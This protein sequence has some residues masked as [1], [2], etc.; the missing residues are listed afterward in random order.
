MTTSD[1]R[2]LKLA[3]GGR[4]LVEASA[5]TGKTWTIAALYLRLLLEPRDGG[6]VSARGI[7]VSTFTDAAAQELRQRIRARLQGAQ[8]LLASVRLAPHELLDRDLQD[9][10]V[11]HWLRTLCMSTDGSVDAGKVE[12]CHL[13]LQLALAELDQAPIGTLHALCHRILR[14]QPFASGMGFGQIELVAGSELGSELADDLWRQLAQSPEPLSAE[15]QVWFDA[16][17]AKLTRAL[18][19]ALKPGVHVP[20]PP[21]PDIAALLQ[22]DMAHA[23]RER[24][25][26]ASWF[27]STKSVWTR[28]LRG[29]ADWIDAGDPNTGPDEK[30]FADLDKPIETQIKPARLAEAEV[31]D[32]FAFAMHAAE[33]LAKAPDI[34]RARGLAQFAPTLRALRDARLQARG[35]L[36]FDAVI[37]RVHAALQA[38]PALAD[39]LH[40]QWPVAL[41]DEFQ[42]TDGLQ[43]D[44]LDR[45]HRDAMGSPRGRLVMIGDPKQAIYRF[46]GG[47]IDAY[48]RAACDV[49]PDDVMHLDTNYRSAGGYVVACNEFF[50][51]AGH[52]LSADTQHA[53]A[54]RDVKASSRRD[55]KPY[56]IDAIPVER[57]LVFHY[58]DI[59]PANADARRDAALDACA[60]HIVQLLSGTH[61]IGD[62]PLQPG[63]IAVLLPKNKHVSALRMRL[64]ARGVPCVG[65]GRSSVFATDWAHELQLL[66]HAAAEPG[67]P[68]LV[69]AALATRIGGMDYPGLRAL[70][71]AGHEAEWQ[72][73]LDRFAALHARWQ[74][75]GVL[76][77]VSEIIDAAAPRLVAAQDGERALTDLRHLGE[78]LQ[79]QEA[80]QPGHAQL[81]AWLSA[82]RDGDGSD[83][84][85][86]AN[87]R[88]LRIES[89]A[90][91]VQLMTLHAAKGLEFPVV[92]L[93]L[94][95]D[96]ASHQPPGHHG[97]VIVTD[98][99][100]GIRQ[101]RNDA[102][103]CEQ[104][105]R[106]DQEERFRLL[107]VA[108]T[109]AE[110]VCHVYVLPTD[111]PRDGR[112]GSTAVEDPERSPL[113][114][115]LVRARTA[116][117]NLQDASQHI[118]WQLGWPETSGIHQP[119]LAPRQAI[120]VRP[121]PPAAQLVR[122]HSFS[123]MLRGSHGLQEEHAATDE[124]PTVT[125]DII[126][127]TFEEARMTEDVVPASRAHPELAA[128]AQWRGTEIGLALHDVLEQRIV[129]VPIREQPDLVRDCLRK[130]GV[131]PW[132]EG[133]ELEQMLG[134]I[135]QRLDATLD[136]ELKSGLRLSDLP[137]HSLRAEMAFDYVLGDAST[138]RLRAVCR[139]AGE[140]ALMPVLAM[141]TLRG[142]MNGKIDLVFEHA[143]RFHVLDWK[144]NWLGDQLENYMPVTL[145]AA[146]DVHHYRLQALLYTV[147]LHRYLRMRLGGSYR[148]A[149]H[150]GD[151]IY[152]FLRAVGLAP[153]AGVWTQPFSPALIASVDAVLAGKSEIPA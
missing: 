115:L 70:A 87:G 29:L 50:D 94:M 135:A 18:G 123:S 92:L 124:A 28:G 36:S 149:E 38:S 74:S 86:A 19:D 2:A 111:R 43:Y 99:V 97:F 129:G 127:E 128:L 75:S 132:Q 79:A 13:R 105:K 96:N 8:E 101:L 56:R 76:A 32:V 104:A 144:G 90:R 60:D 98:P 133:P 100:T 37:A 116:Q 73:Y 71:D 103:A 72:Q 63:D 12:T 150:L 68:G 125:E 11:L 59:A 33:V 93:P 30:V 89:D 47:D 35:Q 65:G 20:C 24:A 69:R 143:G 54:Y 148:Q 23:L 118:A 91:R 120:H 152:L 88:E 140:E 83:G 117:G 107:Y 147:A 9:D 21:A 82:Q 130:Q 45:I 52:A 106:E 6:P 3:P 109:R 7:V 134:F 4:S 40:A 39:A 122:R 44:I 1:W 42:D 67:D 49:D 5:G 51:I 14:E 34:L 53:I 26:D 108:L 146:M 139:A 15:Q 31:D 137:A 46:R 126:E 145:P 114:A 85:D 58:L 62:A 110:H 16:G 136:A 57:P 17:R 78:L 153:G 121:E 48:L 55:S 64:Q 84:E 102:A 77:V 151:P 25:D 80:R 66:L 41:V 138:E 113:D 22:P 141:H 61:M 119:H 27:K 10:E 81:L 131:R 112:K 142:L 95:W